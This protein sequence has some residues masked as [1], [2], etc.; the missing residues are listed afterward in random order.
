ML[1]WLVAWK[2]LSG[3]TSILNIINNAKL[4]DVGISQ[5]AWSN[6]SFTTVIHVERRPYVVH[7]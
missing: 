2:Y 4:F 6:D 3:F 7:Y 5:D 1:F